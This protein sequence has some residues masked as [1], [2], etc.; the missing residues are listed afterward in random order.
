MPDKTKKSTERI[1]GKYRLVK[2]AGTGGMGEVW[3]ARDADGKDVAIKIMIAGENAHEQLID[4]F[5]RES[6]MMKYLDHRNICHII[7]YGVYQKTQYIAMDFLDGVGLDKI[8][9]M[10]PSIIRELNI[11]EVVNIANGKRITDDNSFSTPATTVMHDGISTY[12]KEDDRPGL[13]EKQTLALFDGILAGMEFA[14]GKGIIHRDIKPSNVMIL[15]SG[16]PVLMDFGLAKFVTDDVDLTRSHQVM[17][18]IDFMSPEQAISAKNVDELSDIFS[19]GALLY[20]MVTG[21]KWFIS[22]GDLLS[23]SHQIQVKYPK[24]PRKVYGNISKEL[25][26]IILKAM[27]HEPKR[28]YQT[29]SAFREDIKRY[30]R[31]DSIRAKRQSLTYKLKRKAKKNKTLAIATVIILLLLLTTGVTFWVQKIKE[32]ATWGKPVFVE[33]FEDNSWKK[34]WVIKEGNFKVENGRLITKNGKGNAFFIFYNKKL[35]G[36]VAIEFEGKFLKGANACDLSVCWTNDF[37]NIFRSSYLFQAGGNFNIQCS[38]LRKKNTVALIPIKL[39]VGQKYKIRAEIDGNML[40]LHIDGGKIIEYKD[41]FP[42]TT[43]YI[44]FYSHAA[45]DAFDNVKIYRKGVAERIS[46]LDIGDSYYSRGDYP[47]ATL[48]YTKVIHSHKGKEIAYVASHKK[49][50]A[51]FNSGKKAEAKQKWKLLLN[52]PFLEIQYYARLMLT[53]FAFEKFQDEDVLKEL[54]QLYREGSPS[55]KQMVGEHLASFAHRSEYNAS[56]NYRKKYNQLFPNNFHHNYLNFL[57]TYEHLYYN[58]NF[59]KSL[60]LMESYFSSHAKDKDRH[61][62]EY[63]VLALCAKARYLYDAGRKKDFLV[64]VKKADT[65]AKTHFKV[66]ERYYFIAKMQTLFVLLN[67]K[68]YDK[69]EKELNK[70]LEKSPNIDQYKTDL[71]TT[72]KGRLYTIKG[73]YNNAIAFFDQKLKSKKYSKTVKKRILRSKIKNLLIMKKYKLALAEIDFYSFNFQR[74]VWKG[75]LKSISNHLNEAISIFDND[76]WSYKWKFQYCQ[77]QKG[78]ALYYNNDERIDNFLNEFTAKRKRN[79]DRYRKYAMLFQAL[80]YIQKNKTNEANILLQ[81]LSKTTEKNVKAVASLILGEI[82]QKELFKIENRPWQKSVVWYF[83]GEYYL[84]KKDLQN[85]KKCFKRAK[86]NFFLKI[87]ISMPFT[88]DCIIYINARLEQLKKIKQ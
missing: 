82:N 19:L 51:L 5:T 85:A 21:K 55:I 81:K 3:L 20:Y 74:I 6:D 48:E 86:E 13:S 65:Y 57:Y 59:S 37:N 75:I 30:Q 67:E 61:Q 73:E 27:E 38:I 1:F 76:K 68:Q 52:V 49:A 46:S 16:E 45:G 50:L 31:G 23:D 22:Q 83:L 35:H 53:E 88:F 29:V 63:M 84:A 77:F 25:E 62:L 28:R 32:L 70:I 15:Q 2:L 14:H 34:N 11:H 87:N 58:G 44:G 12:K 80:K 18:T 33:R 79:G 60:Q 64:A 71:S 69:V 56:I 9:Y 72:I 17:G 43:G 42:I 7:E 41:M 47:N 40:Y 26:T 24:P 66:N 54:E 78:L 39:K 36:S 4:R 10:H 8:L